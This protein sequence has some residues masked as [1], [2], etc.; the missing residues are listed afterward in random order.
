MSGIVVQAPD[1]KEIEFPP[2]MDKGAVQAA[3]QKLYPPQSAKPM[4]WGEVGKQALSNAVPS[5]EKLVGSMAAPIMHPMDTLHAL[6][7]ALDHPQVAASQIG[8]AIKNRYGSMEAFKHT[9]ATDPVGALSDLTLVTPGLGEEGLLSKASNLVQ[10]ADPTK[11]VAKAVS[12]GGKGAQKLV[13]EG[14]GVTTGVGPHIVG[15]AMQGSAD[16]QKGLRGQV[17]EEDLFNAAR[18]AAQ[19]MRDQKRE[20]YLKG[21]KGLEDPSLTLSKWKSLQGQINQSFGKSIRKF[22]VSLNKDGTINMS[23]SPIPD[24]TP[25]MQ[26]TLSDIVSWG[27]KKEDFTPKGLDLLKQRLSQY[28]QDSSG[29]EKAFIAPVLDTV[30]GILNKHVPGYQKTMQKYESDT[31]NLDEIVKTLSLKNTSTKDTFLRKIKT[32]LRN[33]DYRVKL[34]DALDKHSPGLMDQ[35]SGYFMQDATPRGITGRG[36]LGAETMGAVFHAPHAIPALAGGALVSSPR[37]M[38]EILSTVGKHAASMKKALPN[39]QALYRTGQAEQIL[40]GNGS[41]P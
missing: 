40:N 24:L 23:R 13:K 4:G 5:A 15:K 8:Q 38:G 9:L 33:S 16:F 6:G 14:L 34:I 30:K 7:Q 28:T 41:K 3:M 36:I 17:A 2:S 37:L 12:A 31:R 11:A 21:I 27:K 18:D 25:Q 1:G 39:P 22:G 35:L 20:E 10:K 32:G 29:R 26:N 19:S